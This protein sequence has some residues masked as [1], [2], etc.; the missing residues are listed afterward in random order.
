MDPPLYTPST[1]A[2]AGEHDQNISEEEA[3]RIVGVEYAEKI[4]SLS[5]AVYVKAAT[6]AASR[7]IILADTKFEFGLDESTSPP[8]VVLIDEVLTPDSS[9]FWSAEHYAPGR[10]Q[11][12]F[13]KQY[14]RDWLIQTGKKGQENVEMP[15]DVIEDTSK[16]YLDAYRMLTGQEL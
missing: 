14:L 10:S 11:A 15:Q 1:K 8:S 7:G 6:Y 2:E 9:R 16:R 5:L 4:K 13:D 12:S 3:A